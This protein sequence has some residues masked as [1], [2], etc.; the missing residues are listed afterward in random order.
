MNETADTR[1]IAQACSPGVNP[2]CGEACM[3]FVDPARRAAFGYQNETAACECHDICAQDVRDIC[4]KTRTIRQCVPCTTDGR[5]GCRRGFLPD[6]VPEVCSWRVLCADEMLSPETGCDRIVNVIEFE[7]V[8]RYGNGTLAVITPRDTFNCFWYEFARFPSGT[9]YANTP[10]GLMLFRN[11]LA[12]IDGSCKVIV[13]ESVAISSQGN[14]CVLEITYKVV[15]K[16][17]KHENL[18]ISALKPYEENITVAK[19]FEQGHR[20]GTCPENDVCSGS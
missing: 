6:G 19:E 10:E 7:V 8:L 14:S 16:L 12:M 4:T 18:L 1:R 17:W 15:D 9:F 3:V 13:I 5:A 11:E 2:N 20:I